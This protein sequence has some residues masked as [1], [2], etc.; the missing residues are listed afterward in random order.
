MAAPSDETRTQACAEAL[1]LG[2]DEAAALLRG[3]ELLS[4]LPEEDLAY[5]ASRA[6]LVALPAGGLLFGPG[7]RA[8]RFYVVR[9]GEIGVY[10]AE[11]GRE[12]L[13]PGRE[14]ARYVA[15]DAIGDFDFAVGAVLDAEAR[16]DAGAEALAFPRRGMGMQDLARERP[17]AAARI[18]LRALSM[19][20]SRLRS[21]Q[22]LI[23]E[24]APWVRELRHQIYTDA[25]TGLWSRAFLDEEVPRSLEE[26]TAIILL[27][28][29]RFKELNDQHG[30][31]A[32]DQAMS[33]LSGILAAQAERLGRGWAI[34]MRSNE[35]AVV[36]PRCAAEEALGLAAR[37]SAAVAAMRVPVDPR[38]AFTASL[39]VAVWPDDRPD[40]KR[41]VEEAYGL[42]TRAWRA[43]GDRI[44]RLGAEGEGS[45]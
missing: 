1:P 13:S 32:G 35:T 40:W 25:A 22:R 26:P 23:S 4:G 18:L 30:H 17:E 6:E 15:G 43:G 37:L 31:Q 29:D 28:P 11:E 16:A 34:R 7:E 8:K 44:L 33:A 9:S 36:V 10:R 41:L 3:S 19:I 38:F 24:N 42:L 12:G 45:R 27:K 2:C 20:S 21:T 14:L 39:A 5:A